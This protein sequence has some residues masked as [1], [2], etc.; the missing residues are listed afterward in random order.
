MAP[1]LFNVIVFV[2]VALKVNGVPPVRFNVG[3]VPLIVYVQVTGLLPPLSV[4][5]V[6][7]FPTLIV[8]PDCVKVGFNI[9]VPLPLSVLPLSANVPEI[10]KLLIEEVIVDV[11][12]L[13][14][15]TV[16]I[17]TFTDAHDRVPVPVMVAAVLAAAA[18]F[19]VTAS[20]TFNV[21]PVIVNVCKVVLVNL[22]EAIE[23][24]GATVTITLFRAAI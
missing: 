13:V 5:V 16:V 17:P 1:V 20:V 10:V 12:E 22:I 11:R 4:Y 15:R 14:G 2:G 6:L 19:N 23:F 24:V 8:P 18:L 7:I 21:T 9:L 3:V